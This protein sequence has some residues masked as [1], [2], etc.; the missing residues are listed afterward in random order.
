MKLAN[1]CVYRETFENVICE[2]IEAI[3]EQKLS[4]SN[5]KQASLCLS[6]TLDTPQEPQTLTISIGVEDF[7]ALLTGMFKCDENAVVAAVADALTSIK[8]P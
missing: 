3:A 8:L 7:P 1:S 6:F 5:G 4:G 2:D